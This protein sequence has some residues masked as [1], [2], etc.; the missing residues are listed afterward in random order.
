[1]VR[2]FILWETN[3]SEDPDYPAY[4]F[5]FT[6]YSPTRKDVLKKDIKVSDSRKQIE[7]IYDKNIL[8]N[9]KKGWKPVK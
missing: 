9:V 7:S 3:K 5:H 2:K 4:V 8:E 6:D 1:M